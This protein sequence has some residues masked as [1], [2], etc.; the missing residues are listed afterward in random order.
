MLIDVIIILFLLMG[1]IVG[2][3]RG[4]FKS[5]V[6]FIGTILVLII[7]F[8]LKN[9]LSKLMYTCLAFFNLGGIF[10][11][12]KIFNIF[13]YEAIAFLIA[14]LILMS[15]LHV[16]IKITGLFELVLK[17]TIVLG[18]PSKL[19]GAIFGLF[20]TYIFVFLILFVGSRLSFLAPMINESSISSFIMMKSPIISNITNDYYVAFEE[21]YSLK[22]KYLENNNE[23]EYNKE[24]LDILLKYELITVDSADELVKKGKLDFNGANEVID[25]YR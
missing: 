22:D 5:A 7:A 2:F 21:I 16:I 3:K 4:V 19:L 15:L 10:G 13:L 18:V 8:Y 12:I 23:E 9:P 11:G 14:Y 1:M 17:F 25:K 6:M 24:A 20:E